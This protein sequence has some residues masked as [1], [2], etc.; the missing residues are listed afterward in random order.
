MLKLVTCVLGHV[1]AIRKVIDTTDDFD[2]KLEGV[3][4]ERFLGTGWQ[5]NFFKRFSQCVD[6]GTAVDADRDLIALSEDT[7]NLMP[8][9]D[10]RYI[11]VYP[12]TVSLVDDC[13]ELDLTQV[14]PFH[15]EFRLSDISH[16]M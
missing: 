5:A 7:E 13:E 1:V 3:S 15:T 11:Q 14:L 4:C 9:P 16:T 6:P 12:S 2:Y 10:A 8:R